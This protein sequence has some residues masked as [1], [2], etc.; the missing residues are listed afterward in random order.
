MPL[1]LLFCITLATLAA[2]CGTAVGI[3]DEPLY[4]LKG[5]PNVPASFPDYAV[6]MHF[7]TQG[8][9]DMTKAQIDAISQGMVMMPLQ[10][11]DDFNVEVGKLCSQVKC[12]YETTSK[13]A[14]F[15]ARLHAA[16]VK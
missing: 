16:A 10:S 6:E 4:F 15:I 11:F 2:S 1:S 12:N 14:E 8:Q 7:L 9:A 3:K 5:N 13:L